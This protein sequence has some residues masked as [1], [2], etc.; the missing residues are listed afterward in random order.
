[1]HVDKNAMPC[2]QSACAN[3]RVGRNIGD[4]FGRGSGGTVFVKSDE[5]PDGWVSWDPLTCRSS[6]PRPSWSSK[7]QEG[8]HVPLQKHDCLVRG[9]AVCTPF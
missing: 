3:A 4:S 7:I 2:R 8:C 1:M 6:L 5:T 9:T